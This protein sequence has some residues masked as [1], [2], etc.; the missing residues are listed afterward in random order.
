M[1]ILDVQV[2]QR[3]QPFK[4]DYGISS[5]STVGEMF[6]YIRVVA[7]NGTFGIG[8]GAPSVP[9][10]NEDYGTAAHVIRRYLR[11]VLIGMDSFDVELIESRMDKALPQHP[12]AKAGIDIAVHDLNAKLLGVP[13]HTLLGGLVRRK[14]PLIYAIGIS[15]TERMIAEA[16]EA[17]ER[18]F[19]TVKLKIGIN[20]RTDLERV[21]EVRRIIGDDVRLRVD[22]NQGCSLSEYM[23]TFRKMESLDLEFLEQPLPVW[24]V[25]GLRKLA[26]ALDTPILI[27]E[28]I[29]TP[30]DLINLIRRDAV[31][32]VNIKVE[33]TGLSGGKRIGAIAEAAGLPCIVGS[34]IETSVGTAAGVHFAAATRSVTHASE[35][36]GPSVFFAEEIVQGEPFSVVPPDCCWE[37]STDV[38][39]GLTMRPEVMTLFESIEDRH[40]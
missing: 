16:H 25:E 1:R 14:V 27:D 13:V 8:E 7:E 26:S 29:Y 40:A 31:D 30:Y 12:M 39:L 28:G 20:P 38:G 17:V 32:A 6:L 36:L 11:P 23:Q 22:A 3:Y 4:T 34:M 35:M 19:G 21:R 2:I 9:F 24:D 18:G 10:S 37:V 5:S 33:K 15:S